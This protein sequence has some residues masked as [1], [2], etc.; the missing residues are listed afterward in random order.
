MQ[1]ERAVWRGG[2][3][4][5][6]SSSIRSNTKSVCLLI[7]PGMGFLTIPPPTSHSLSLTYLSHSESSFVFLTNSA[8]PSPSCAS[9]HLSAWMGGAPPQ[10]LTMG[11]LFA[12]VMLVDPQNFLWKLGV[13]LARLGFRVN[14][15]QLFTEWFLAVDIQSVLP[16]SGTRS[17]IQI[18]WTLTKHLL[19]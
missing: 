12:S 6:P 17:E 3:G 10:H 4:S 13:A 11:K 5:S 15:L 18:I 1:Q 16:S 2:R 19:G 14:L 8:F 7:F 9:Q